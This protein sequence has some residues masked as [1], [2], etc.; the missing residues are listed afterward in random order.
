VPPASGRRD[1]GHRA[2]TAA[3]LQLE[4]HPAAEGIADDVS[5]APAQ[6]LHPAF[7]IVGQ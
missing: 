6:G 7:D 4:G 2:G 1:T 5:G 3:A